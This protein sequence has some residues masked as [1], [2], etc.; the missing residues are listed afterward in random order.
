MTAPTGKG[1]PTPKRSESQRRRS[2]PTWEDE[3]DAMLDA[4]EREHTSAARD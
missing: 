1:R 3:E 2:G 4:L